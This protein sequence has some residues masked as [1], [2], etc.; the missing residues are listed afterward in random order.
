MAINIPIITS[1]EDKGIKAAKAAFANFKTSVA[2][3]EGGMNKFKAGSK[4]ALDAVGANAQAFAIAGG[5]AFAKFAMQGVKAFETLALESSKFA[6][7][8]G[9]TV[10]D[11][12]RWKEVAGDIGI[13]SDSIQTAI[14]KMNK[15]L[16]TS[17]QLF[18]ELGIEIAKTDTG[19]TDVNQTFLNVI[20]KL[21]GIKDPAERAKVATQLLGKGWMDMAELIQKGSSSLKASLSD[22]SDSKVIDPKEVEKAKNLRETMDN[23]KD[24][25]DDLSL[26]IGEG[27]IPL[28]SDIGNLV[29]PLE[30]LNSAML[31][32]PGVSW[33]KEHFGFFPTIQLGK[34]IFNGLSDAMSGV[35]GWFKDDEPPKKTA[36]VFK[37]L[38]ANGVG[39]FDAFKAMKGGI[40]TVLLAIKGAKD[41]LIPFNNIL[42]DTWKEIRNIDQAW[43]DLIGSL[44]TDVDIDEARTSLDDLGKA[45]AKAFTTGSAED[46][47]A[48][49]EQLLLAATDIMNLALDMD[50]ISSHEVKVL[51][52]TGDLEGAY[53]LILQ[54][55]AFQ[56]T[57][58]N[59]SD[60][61][62]VMAGANAMILP[63]GLDFSG[64]KAS[65]GPVA[66]GS[67]YLVGERGPELFT[68]SSSG[69]ITPNGAMGGNTINITVTSADPN[70]VVRALQSY[71]RNVGKIPVSVQ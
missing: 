9:L 4:S 24:A 1:L 25:V 7:A 60:P 12:S 11:A 21:K 38:I 40:F 62:A 20:D 27:L 39:L 49:R 35:W 15:E 3:V 61:F 32:I 47:A 68:P 50:N 65:G 55:K 48:Y 57:Y 29:K 54:I 58:A 6:D 17:P 71:N 22:V 43:K 59:V 41:E 56:K 66:G 37:L 51:V 52:D 36:E 19:A 2:D 10:Q 8:T 5:I 34:D 28:L 13:G 33:A 69:N 18:N 44:Q 26:A 53:A 31:K 14:N 63:P 30:S 46:I 45:A 70:A 42:N 64:F 67:T 23:L 16:G